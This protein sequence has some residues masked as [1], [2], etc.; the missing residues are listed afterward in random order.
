[1]TTCFRHFHPS[2]QNLKEAAS[3][4]FYIIFIV[5]YPTFLATNKHFI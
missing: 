1:M 2:F 3:I 4:S 5:C